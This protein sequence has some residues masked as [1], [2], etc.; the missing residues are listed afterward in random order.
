[1]HFLSFYPFFFLLSVITE[2]RLHSWNY[3]VKSFVSKRVFAVKCGVLIQSV[4]PVCP[5]CDKGLPGP[6]LTP[7]TQSAQ[8]RA[9]GAALLQLSA[10]EGQQIFW[11][12]SSWLS[13][14][15]APG[16]VLSDKACSPRA[17]ARP[18][19]CP[20]GPGLL[21]QPFLMERESAEV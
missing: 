10:R 8:P 12:P 17:P 14:E 3:L 7:R 20:G 9:L 21:Q 4:L 15:M 19:A 13:K 5:W 6:A 18:P 1:M 16:K 2:L 11:G